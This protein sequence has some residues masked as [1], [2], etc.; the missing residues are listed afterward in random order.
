MM[1]SHSGVSY[2]WAPFTLSGLVDASVGRVYP[3]FA[4][5]TAPVYHE[6]CRDWDAAPSVY[7]TLSL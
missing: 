7:G 6:I 1:D 4:S 3:A 2:K 5:L